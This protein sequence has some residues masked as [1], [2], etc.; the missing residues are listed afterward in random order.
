MSDIYTDTGPFATVPEWILFGELSDRAVRLF[1]ILQRHDG[2][3]GA[4]P[5]RRRLATILSCSVDSVDRAMTELVSQDIV[6]K[7][8]RYK[9]DGSQRSNLY[10]LRLGLSAPLRPPSRIPAVHNES[11]I[12]KVNSNLLGKINEFSYSKPTE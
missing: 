10:E 3:Q 9:E 4:F 6:I 12:K 2:K 5:S 1:G 8:S 11:N 7:H